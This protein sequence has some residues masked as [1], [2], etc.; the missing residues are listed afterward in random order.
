VPGLKAIKKPRFR[1]DF[2][3][4]YKGKPFL[5]Q[6]DKYAVPDSLR[7]CKRHFMYFAILISLSPLISR[8]SGALPRLPYPFTKTDTKADTSKQ[9]DPKYTRHCLTYSQ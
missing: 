3:S 5:M 9:N 8:K 4:S 6:Y 2:G 7:A 1:G